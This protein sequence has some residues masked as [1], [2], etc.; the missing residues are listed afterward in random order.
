M[1][2]DWDGYEPFDPGIWGPLHELSRKD[3]R[4][5]YDRLMSE[6]PQRIEA[7]KAV[8][9]RNGVISGESLADVQ[10]LNDWF[11][12]EVEPDEAN[13]ARLRPIWYSVVND[14]ALFLG[15]L[16]IQRSPNLKWTFFD[17]RK[18]D[19]AFQRHV[20]IGFKEVANPDFYIDIDA[21]VASDAHRIIVGKPVPEDSFCRI[22]RYA[23]SKA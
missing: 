8:L 11:R 14:I 20:I 5:A 23:E 2:V 4:A 3:A 19:A 1:S 18:K 10:A 13:P 21:A 7:L 9:E 22:L 6:K 12:V 17:K 15:D 16:M